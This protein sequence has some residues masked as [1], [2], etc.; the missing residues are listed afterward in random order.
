M[1]NIFRR[2]PMQK[3]LAAVRRELDTF[4]TK[5]SLPKPSGS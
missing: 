5:R 3:R 2:E 1:R 4:K